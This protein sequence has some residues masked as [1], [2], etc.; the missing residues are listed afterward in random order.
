MFEVFDQPDTNLTCERRDVTTVPTQALTLLNNEFVLMQAKL[1]A[2][3]VAHEA[4][5]DPAARVTQAYRIAFSRNPSARE[6]DE[7]LKFLKK[8]EAASSGPAETASLTALA[9]L[10]HVIFNSNEF[11]YIN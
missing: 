11:V 3:R 8:R 4:G 6:L 5:G 10:T 7:S 2:E 1:L 9:E